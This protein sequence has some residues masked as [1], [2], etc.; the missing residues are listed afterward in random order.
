M[1]GFQT[2]N[3]LLHKHKKTAKV[4]A[5][6]STNYVFKIFIGWNIIASKRL[7]SAQFFSDFCNKEDKQKSPFIFSDEA[8]GFPEWKKNRQT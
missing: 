8:E 7:F 4:I 5:D 2:L 3:N 1:F 6:I